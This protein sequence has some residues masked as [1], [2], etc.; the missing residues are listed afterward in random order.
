M[1]RVSGAAS[2]DAKKQERISYIEE[3]FHIDN[4][5]FTR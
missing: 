3:K 4:G 1:T 5:V 2:Q